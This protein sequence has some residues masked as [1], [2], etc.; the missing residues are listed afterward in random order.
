MKL[1][2]AGPMR[3][4]P[5]FNFAAFDKAALEL[6]A[7]GYNVFNPAERD[8]SA[9]GPGFNKSPKGDLQDLASSG[10]SLRDALDADLAWICQHAEGVALLPGWGD[11]LGAQ[12]EVRVAMALGIP[13]NWVSQW[14]ADAS[15]L[16]P[17]S[18]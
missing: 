3:G 15:K 14:I 8:R 7:A 9:Y 17:A 5:D 2:L 16:I 4:Y 13:Y 6:R 1:Y 18:A 11:S 12:A 10:F